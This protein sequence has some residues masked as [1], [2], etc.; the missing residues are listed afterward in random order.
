VT[1]NPPGA[2]SFTADFDGDGKG[3]L[4]IYRPNDIKAQSG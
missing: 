2:L 3:D 1:H 4:A